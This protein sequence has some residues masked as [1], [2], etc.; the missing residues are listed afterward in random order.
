M[1]KMSDESF[2]QA[3]EYMAW[4]DRCAFQQDILKR[5]REWFEANTNE[6]ASYI[7]CLSHMILRTYNRRGIVGC[8]QEYI[9]DNDTKKAI[10]YA[11]NS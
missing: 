6:T 11:F 10:A 3:L 5:L 2:L 4:K 9:A 1:D 7:E 8:F